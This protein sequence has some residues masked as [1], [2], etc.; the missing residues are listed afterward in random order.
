MEKGD[1]PIFRFCPSERR[2]IWMSW[3]ADSWAF[4]TFARRRGRPLER[5]GRIG[6][7]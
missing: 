4:A 6:N 3:T 5:N 1:G 2:L 7:G